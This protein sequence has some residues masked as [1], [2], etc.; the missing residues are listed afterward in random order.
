MHVQLTAIFGPD[1][2]EAMSI[3]LAKLKDL[4]LDYQPSD[5][6]GRRWIRIIG[7]ADVGDFTSMVSQLSNVTAC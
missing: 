3:V 5:E 2:D 4:D 1:D 6:E 7:A